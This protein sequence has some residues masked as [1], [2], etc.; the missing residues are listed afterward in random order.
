MKTKEFIRRVKDLGFTV[1]IL[2][3]ENPLSKTFRK[4]AIIEISC[5]DD[6]VAKV[7]MRAS[8]AIN[9]FEGQHIFF[10]YKY[11]MDALYELCFEYVKTPVCAREEEKKFYLRHRCLLQN[12][13]HDPVYL[14]YNRIFDTIHVYNNK[15]TDVIQTQFTKK[16]IEEIKEK[17]NTDLKDFELVEV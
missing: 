13:I 17:F 10:H 7:W 14:N 11:D 1:E 12:F 15:Q 4:P 8:Y 6:L 3:D 2:M 9:T 5:D 16:E